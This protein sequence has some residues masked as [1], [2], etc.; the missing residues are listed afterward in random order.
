[1]VHQSVNGVALMATKAVIQNQGRQANSNGRAFEE[2]IAQRLRSSGYQQI[3]NCPKSFQSP[4]FVPQMR[5]RFVSIYGTDMRVDFFVWH[6]SKYP[7]GLVIECKYQ[8][9]SGSA[10]EKFPYTIAN[11]RKTGI[12]AILLVMGSGPKRCAI[13]WCMQQQD[14]QLTVF[15]DFESFMKSANRDLF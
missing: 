6:P 2:M 4:F 9:T 10:D 8:E 7:N 11:L 13:E 14:D 1:M 5:G 12:P 3:Q 15:K